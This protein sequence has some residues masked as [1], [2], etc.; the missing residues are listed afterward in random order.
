MLTLIVAGLVGLTVV[1]D[2]LPGIKKR[3]KKD[4]VVYCLLLAVGF[5]VL[6]LYSLDVNVPSPSKL[7]RSVVETL[8][9]VK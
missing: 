9:P 4:S 8:F 7:I 5:I 1:F 2:L 6:L 3:P